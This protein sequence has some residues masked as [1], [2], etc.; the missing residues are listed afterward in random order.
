MITVAWT[1]KENAG[2]YTDIENPRMGTRD[3]E[4]KN[5]GKMD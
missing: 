2:Y 1:R 3:K 5:Q 4:G